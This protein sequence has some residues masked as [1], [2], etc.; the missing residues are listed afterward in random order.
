M[1]LACSMGVGGEVPQACSLCASP[2]APVCVKAGR[3][4]LSARM[5]WM[6]SLQSDLAADA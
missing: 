2:T 3:L 5:F 6:G 4:A 1:K